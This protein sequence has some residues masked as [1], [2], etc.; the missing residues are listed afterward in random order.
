[1]KKWIKLSYQFD[2]KED[3]SS[4]SFATNEDLIRNTKHN[5]DL[6]AAK[7]NGHFLKDESHI[8]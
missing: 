8:N 6:F 1:M 2:I 4:S 5:Y 3:C 7:E